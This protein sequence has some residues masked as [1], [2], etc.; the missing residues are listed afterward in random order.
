MQEK[1]VFEYA[2]IR[3][4]PFVEREE[5]VNVGVILHCAKQN[6]LSVRWQIDQPFL[7]QFAPNLDI[8]E[9]EQNLC[10]FDKIS[11]GGPEGGTIGL[12]DRAGR[13]RWMTATRST[14]LQISNVHPGYTADAQA[15]LLRLFE[16]LVTRDA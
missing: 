8:N 15:T 2:V 7:Q 5:F 12:M 1:D 4:V 3:V 13:F 11:L 14:I 16:Q 6:F 10:A 9:L